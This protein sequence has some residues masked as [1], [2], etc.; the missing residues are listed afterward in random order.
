MAFILEAFQSVFLV[1]ICILNKYF[2]ATA[3]NVYNASPIACNRHQFN[4]VDRFMDI[5][6]N[7]TDPCNVSGNLFQIIFKS[8]LPPL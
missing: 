8:N 3:C 6:T 7:W 4:L 1:T 2:N 5:I